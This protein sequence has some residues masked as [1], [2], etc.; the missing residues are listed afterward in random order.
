MCECIL[1][2]EFLCVFFSAADLGHSRSGTISH[3]NSKLLPKCK[4]CN[5]CIWYHAP[6]NIWKLCALAGRCTTLRCAKC[7]TNHYRLLC[8]LHLLFVDLL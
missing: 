7:C 5:C 2:L 4:W 1:K 3:H 6:F 8:N